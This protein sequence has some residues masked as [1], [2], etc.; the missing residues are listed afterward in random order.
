MVQ[1]CTVLYCTILPGRFGETLLQPTPGLGDTSFPVICGQNFTHMLASTAPSATIAAAI[2]SRVRGF[3][4]M[5]LRR[6]LGS[7]GF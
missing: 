6:N 2:Q 3:E 1:C 5:C 4:L 7:C